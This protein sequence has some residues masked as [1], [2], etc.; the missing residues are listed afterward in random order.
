MMSTATTTTTTTTKGWVPVD[1]DELD[2]DMEKQPV[3]LNELE[4]QQK[5][6]M[7]HN[8]TSRDVPLATCVVPMG[9]AVDAAD[10]DE[11]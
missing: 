7:D 11:K 5:S 6:T 1:L 4:E 8:T 2:D 9:I 3:D 10:V